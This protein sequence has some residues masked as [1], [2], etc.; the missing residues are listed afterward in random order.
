MKVKKSAKG[1]IQMIQMQL[2]RK[3]GLNLPLAMMMRMSIVQDFKSLENGKKLK[4]MNLR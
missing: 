4:Q 2:S 3:K 1:S